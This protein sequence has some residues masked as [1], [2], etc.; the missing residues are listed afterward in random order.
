VNEWNINVAS[1]CKSGV[2][3]SAEREDEANVASKE[4]PFAC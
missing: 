1:G 3:A 2:S 4:I